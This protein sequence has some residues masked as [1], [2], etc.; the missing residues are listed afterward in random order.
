MKGSCSFFS[1]WRLLKLS[2]EGLVQQRLLQSLQGGELL[3]VEAGELMAVFKQ[4]IERDDN[5]LLFLKRKRSV[6]R[7]FRRSSF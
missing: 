6:D 3:L 4:T 1:G 5:S 7:M 2:G